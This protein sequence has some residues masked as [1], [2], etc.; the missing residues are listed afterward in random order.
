LRLAL[1]P[2]E[3]YTLPYLDLAEPWPF[4]IGELSRVTAKHRRWLERRCRLQI[5]LLEDLDE[6]MDAFDAL[7][8][9]LHA[10]WHDRGG[11]VLDTPRARRLHRHVLPLLLSGDRPRRIRL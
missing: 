5:E 3:I 11:S 10:R 2:R 4:P 8:R 7:T 6:V 1:Q 9:L